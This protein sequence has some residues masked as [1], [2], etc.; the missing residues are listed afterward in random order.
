MGMSENTTAADKIRVVIFAE[1]YF[2]LAVG[3]PTK[4]EA[5]AFA[6]GVG[7]GASFYGAGSCGA[8][9]L[10]DDEAEMREFEKPEEIEKALRA[11]LK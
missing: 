8:F 4:T 6:S 10:P 7:Q 9:V 2:E 11:E 5:R 3:Y 1:R